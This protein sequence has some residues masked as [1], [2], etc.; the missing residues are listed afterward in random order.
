M[1]VKKIHVQLLL[2]LSLLSFLMITSNSIN[3]ISFSNIVKDDPYVFSNLTARS[4]IYIYS[5]T[6][7][8]SQGFPG[9]GT[10]SDPYIIENYIIADE[11]NYGIYIS[12]VSVYFEIRNCVI[13]NLPY[14]GIRLA[15]IASGVARIYNNTCYNN[16]DRGIHVIASLNVTI[17]YNRCYDNWNAG[18]EIYSSSNC[19]VIDNLCERNNHAGIEL[20]SSSNCTVIDN[21][22]ERNNLAGIFVHRDANNCT[23]VGNEIN[24][25]YIFG[26]YFE[27][28]LSGSAFN[29]TLNNNGYW[30][31]TEEIENYANFVFENNTING[32]KFGYFFNVNSLNFSIPEYGQLIIY[33]SENILIKNQEFINTTIGVYIFNCTSVEIEINNFSNLRDTGLMILYSDTC[34]IIGNDFSNMD[35]GLYFEHTLNVT[36]NDNTFENCGLFAV[37]DSVEDYSAYNF[38]NNFVNSLKLGV[39]INEKDI[40]L[41]APEYGELFLINCTN[42]NI[43]NQVL[44]HTTYGI[45]LFGCDYVNISNSIIDYNF[46]GIAVYASSNITIEDNSLCFSTAGLYIEGCSNIYAI[47]NN[48]SFNDFRGIDVYFT[49]FSEIRENTCQ[50][51]T[52]GIQFYVV[53][54]TSISG[55]H[56]NYNQDFGSLMFYSEENEYIDNEY[57]WNYFGLFT[58][59]SEDLLIYRNKIENNGN[60][61]LYLVD[62]SRIEVSTNN[63]SNNMYGVRLYSTEYCQIIYNTF[64]RN[65]KFGVSLDLRSHHNVVHHNYFIDNNYDGSTSSISQ[66]VDDG[67]NNTWYDINTFEGNWWSG[68]GDFYRIAGVAGSV[69]PFPLNAPDEVIDPP[70]TPEETSFNSYIIL[71]FSFISLSFIRYLLRKNDVL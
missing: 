68:G 9:S 10:P 27:R 16:G 62:S 32:L 18:I 58:R 6:G 71:I 57:L 33:E 59:Y 8:A 46:I 42:F 17:E 39:F 29:N 36:V 12:G 1:K 55:N 19:T 14:T 35:L 25:N 53:H 41:N 49:T 69:D 28:S 47:G 52:Q 13:T 31:Y 56:L 45:L 44:T 4:P 40:S 7:F 64:E 43:Q 37:E 66:A 3:N 5:N 23:I 15:G 60:S 48:C 22:C 24:D 30:V 11:T 34:R 21:L 70:S 20:D 65:S 63:C 61:A 2:F 54:N 67:Y 38:N 50:N 51:N 26:I